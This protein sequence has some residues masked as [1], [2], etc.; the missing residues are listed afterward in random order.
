M[1]SAG[2][3]AGGGAGEKHELDLILFWLL[4]YLDLFHVAS[5]AW[6]GITM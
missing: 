6:Y 5:T 4:F 1:G 3:G 2:L